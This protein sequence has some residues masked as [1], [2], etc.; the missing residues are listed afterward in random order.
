MATSHHFFVL[1]LRPLSSGSVRTRSSLGGEIIGPVQF[2]AEEYIIR[3]LH[4]DVAA[5]LYTLTVLQF[6][7]RRFPHRFVS[8]LLTSVLVLSH[9]RLLG[10]LLNGTL[11]TS[12]TRSTILGID[13][14]DVLFHISRHAPHQGGFRTTGAV[15]IYNDVLAARNSIVNPSIFN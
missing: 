12:P 8:S 7:I 2:E 11:S 3:R 14:V 10:Q 15:W 6:L 9:L 1:I 4:H 5:M 13:P